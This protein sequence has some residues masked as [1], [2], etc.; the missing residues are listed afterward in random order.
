MKYQATINE[1]LSPTVSVE[2][3]STEKVEGQH[4]F[5]GIKAY[6][7]SAEDNFTLYHGDCF[8][9]LPLLSEQ[10]DVIFADPPYFLSNGGISVQSGKIVSVNKGGVGQGPLYG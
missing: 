7:Q 8:E 2:V 6:Y 5:Q 3:P 4:R 9:I 1:T 10:A